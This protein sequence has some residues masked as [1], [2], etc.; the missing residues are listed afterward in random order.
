MDMRQLQYFISVAETL[1]FTKAAKQHY[2]AQQAISQ[3]IAALEKKL[4][5]QLFYRNNRSVQLT[6]AGKVFYKE[7]KIITARLEDA[8]N[9]ALRAASSFEGT[10]KVGFLGP[11][12][13]WF[14]PE[15]IRKFRNSYP[16]IDLTMTQGNLEKLRESIQQGLLDIAFN[17]SLCMDPASGITWKT[18]NRDPICVILYRDHPLANEPRIRLASLA[19]DSFVAIDRREAPFAFDAMVRQCL[20]S[21]FSPKI[22]SQSRSFETVL[23]MVEA[24]TGIALVPRCFEIYTNDKLRFIELEGETETVELVVAWLKDNPNPAIPLFL[25]ALEEHLNRAKEN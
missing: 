3:Q 16:N 14:L 25:K 18:I 11:N 23:F 1:N 17:F 2:I 9:K 12:E 24:E 21:G 7:I 8:I 5:V 22:V 20:N 6:P 4:G 19:N 15:L 13:K 10:L